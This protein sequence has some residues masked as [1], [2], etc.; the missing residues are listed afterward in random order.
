MW[1]GNSMTG[2]FYNRNYR[3]QFPFDSFYQ[4]M[5]TWNDA[6]WTFYAGTTDF[7]LRS[8]MFSY[9]RTT[10]DQIPSNWNLYLVFFEG[11]DFSGQSLAYQPTLDILPLSNNTVQNMKLS[12]IGW[13]DRIHSIL[14]M[15]TLF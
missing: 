11:A 14:V 15:V 10:Y 9:M 6:P 4:H 12:D 2:H 13:G 7:T 8:F 1:G 5:L 3:G